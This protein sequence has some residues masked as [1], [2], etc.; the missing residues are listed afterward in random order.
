MTAWCDT[1]NEAKGLQVVS[2]LQVAKTLLAQIPTL[3]SAI[4]EVVKAFFD[5]HVL[6]LLQSVVATV[7]KHVRDNSIEHKDVA[8]LELLLSD[9]SLLYPL[10]TTIPSLIDDCASW[11]RDTMAKEAHISFTSAL[12]AVEKEDIRFETL[13]QLADKIDGVVAVELGDV[14]LRITTAVEKV[15]KALMG[16]A[17]WTPAHRVTSRW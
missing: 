5:A 13:H 11:Q 1:M 10:S 4:P 15:L 17:E 16:L 6:S 9:T 2:Q 12:L 8:A 3:T 7:G 14:A